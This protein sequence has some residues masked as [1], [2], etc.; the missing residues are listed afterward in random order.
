MSPFESLYGYPAPSISYVLQ[1]H[2]KVDAIES[3]MEENKET[4]TILKENLQMAQ[5]R[6]K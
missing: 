2:S 1:D 4:L 5:N 6:M 3:H